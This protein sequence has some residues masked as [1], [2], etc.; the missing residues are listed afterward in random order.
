MIEAADK[1]KMLVDSRAN[2][3]SDLFSSANAFSFRIR[4]LLDN[5]C[6]PKYFGSGYENDTPLLSW[7]LLEH[8]E[9]LNEIIPFECDVSFST[10]PP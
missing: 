9:I 6:S 4:D 7:T 2:Y 5:A 10:P 8:W 1:T 3:Q